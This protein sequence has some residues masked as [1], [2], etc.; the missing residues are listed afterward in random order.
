MPLGYNSGRGVYS[1]SALLLDTG[2]VNMIRLRR[3]W[4]SKP[5][6]NMI[7]F[8][9]LY[10]RLKARATQCPGFFCLYPKLGSFLV[11]RNEPI[12]LNR[13]RIIISAKLYNCTCLIII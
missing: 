1:Q 10:L 6:E 12:S 3:H 4:Y 7:D 9:D 8:H 13:G 2:M 5:K 11:P